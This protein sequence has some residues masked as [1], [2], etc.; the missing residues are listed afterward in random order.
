MSRDDITFER[1][2][3]YLSNESDYEFPEFM[4]LLRGAY[5]I[6][7]KV[8]NQ[9]TGIASMKLYSLESG[10]F[11]HRPNIEHIARLASYYGISER[12][13]LRKADEFLMKKHPVKTRLRRKQDLV[14]A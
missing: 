3:T 6:S 9:E 14:A 7:R 2:K 4:R 11:L 5:C 10:T 8:V 12:L 1:V 13:L